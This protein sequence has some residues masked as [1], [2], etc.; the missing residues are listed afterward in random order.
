MTRL[1][2][3][4]LGL[5]VL[6][7]GCAE[8]PDPK[9]L[10]EL[11]NST[12]APIYWLGDSYRGLPLVHVAHFGARSDFIYGDC[13]PGPPGSDEPSCVPPIDVQQWR[14]RDRHPS[15]FV[16][17]SCRR[18]TVRGVPVGDFRRAG[19]EFELY[20]GSSTVVIF[21]DDRRSAR[22][23]AQALQPINAPGNAGDPLPPPPPS[24]AKALSVCRPASG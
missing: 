15:L 6:L 20:T 2:W 4:A 14:L 16:G 7:A 3:A 5:T 23:I 10:D 9:T 17:P 1:A 11:R 12:G 24:V 21:T 22:R 13:T 18:L 19:A 8:R